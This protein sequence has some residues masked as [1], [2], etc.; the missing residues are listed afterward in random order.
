MS[1]AAAVLATTLLGGVGI[2]VRNIAANGYTISFVRLGIGFLFL[3]L[4]LLLKGEIKNIATT[5]FSPFLFILGILLAATS[6][7]YMN[8][9]NSTT[10]ANAVFLL[11]LGPF[12][13]V[14]IAAVF[15]KEKLTLL[16]GGLLCLAFLGFLLFDLN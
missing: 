5:K 16:N 4:F 8:A 15:L 14:G 12:I 13:A 7:C 11:Y 6:V 2:F 1:Y 10:L 3:V 9:I